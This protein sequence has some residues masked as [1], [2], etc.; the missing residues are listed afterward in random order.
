MGCVIDI[1]I[2]THI[3]SR[4]IIVCR[5]SLQKLAEAVGEKSVNKKKKTRTYSGK[6]GNLAVESEGAGEEGMCGRKCV[7][8][9]RSISHLL[10]RLACLVVRKNTF[11]DG[12]S[13][14]ISIISPSLSRDRHCC[15]TQWVSVR[16]GMR[17]K[18]LTHVEQPSDA[19]PSPKHICNDW[20][21]EGVVGVIATDSEENYPTA[22]QKKKKK[23]KG[24]I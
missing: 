20:E 11:V 19:S 5:R 14:R 2:Y 8:V 3:R 12:I 16:V 21:G 17:S 15:L 10:L 13:K 7:V 22:R 6:T 24:K 18:G 9:R 23:K 4:S 1:D